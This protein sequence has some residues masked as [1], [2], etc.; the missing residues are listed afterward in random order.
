[1]PNAY[2]ALMPN[3]VPRQSRK[4]MILRHLRFKQGVPDDLRAPDP[5]RFGPFTIGFPHPRRTNGRTQ[6]R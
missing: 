1:M 2:L 3:R 4:E 5:N 6:N